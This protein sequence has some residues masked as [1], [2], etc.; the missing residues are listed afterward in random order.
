MYARLTQ[1]PPG[2]TANETSQQ[3]EELL[4]AFDGESS[5]KH[6]FWEL[7]SYDRVRDPL[8]LS[9]LSPS[10]IRFMTSL[11]VFA[12]T[13]VF[14]I[15]IAVVQYIPTDGGLEQM[16][17][18]VKRNLANCVVLLNEASTWSIIYPD[19]ILKP[20]V[21]IHP[22]PGPKERRGEIV[23]ALCALN[24]ADDASGEEFTAF[25]LAQNLDE[26]FPGATPSVGDLLTDF[27]RIRYPL[28]AHAEAVAPASGDTPGVGV[29]GRGL[30]GG[31]A[32]W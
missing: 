8:S 29:S 19:E 17:W 12:A 13:E 1:S 27:E 3:I 26:S 31:F 20:R 16:I 22:L 5:L 4:D 14:T 23:Q 30:K 32:E 7:L 2:G 25:E 9:I 21:R 10:A 28:N 18:A 11:E 24:A 15:V 6:L